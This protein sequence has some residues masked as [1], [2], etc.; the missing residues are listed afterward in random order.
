PLESALEDLRVTDA[1]HRLAYTLTRTALL[2]LERGRADAAVVH[3]GEAL[4]YAEALDRAT[5]IVLAPVALARA[6]QVAH[7]G[8][9]YQKHI[10]ALARLESAPVAVWARGRAAG[11]ARDAG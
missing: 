6:C 11:L 1:K 5:E 4:T 8:P 10:T 9:G 3:A 7:D 2:D